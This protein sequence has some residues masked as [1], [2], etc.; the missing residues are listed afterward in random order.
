ML[1]VTRWVVEREGNATSGRGFVE[2]DYFFL[3]SSS[4]VS[5]T[6]RNAFC[7]M[8]T[9]PIDFIEI[10]AGMIAIVIGKSDIGQAD[11]SRLI[12]PWLQQLL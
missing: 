6:A 4:P 5:S 7:G 10:D 9:E 12:D 3:P 8:S 1:L 2:E 11:F